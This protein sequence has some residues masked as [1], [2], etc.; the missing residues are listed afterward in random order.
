MFAVWCPKL[1]WR[2]HCCSYTEWKLAYSVGNSFS[3]LRKQRQR[4]DYDSGKSKFSYLITILMEEKTQNMVGRRYQRST[5]SHVSG[6]PQWKRIGAFG[7][8]SSSRFQLLWA[9]LIAKEVCVHKIHIQPIL[10]AYYLGVRGAQTWFRECFQV[11]DQGFNRSMQLPS[12]FSQEILSI[13]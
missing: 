8:S 13:I 3:S 2:P 5:M 6:A 4:V 10:F 1:K 11:E 9:S 12:A 7:S